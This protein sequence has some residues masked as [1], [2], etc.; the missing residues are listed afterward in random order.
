MDAQCFWANMSLFICQDGSAK[1]SCKSALLLQNSSAK[2][3]PPFPTENLQGPLPFYTPSTRSKAYESPV[4]ETHPPL[5]FP[6]GFARNVF[7]ASEKSN[8]LA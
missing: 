1:I 6:M 8:D 3:P 5:H 2:R 7:V 4:R